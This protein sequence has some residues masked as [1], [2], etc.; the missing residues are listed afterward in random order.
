MMFTVR[1][2]EEMEKKAYV[3]VFL[4]FVDLQKAYDSVTCTFLWLV[5]A[6]FGVPPQMIALMNQLYDGMRTC[7]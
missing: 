2:L 7:V 3:S 1:R 6:R 5:L 4:Y